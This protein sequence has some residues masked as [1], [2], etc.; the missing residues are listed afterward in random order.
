MAGGRWPRPYG[1]VYPKIAAME[2]RPDGRGKLLRY[3]DGATDTVGRNGA[4]A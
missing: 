1:T 2:P 4:P 3:A